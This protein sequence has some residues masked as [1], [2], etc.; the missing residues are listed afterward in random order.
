MKKQ[1]QDKTSEMIV[2]GSIFENPPIIDATEKYQFSQDDFTDRLSK[3]IFIAINNLFV[4]DVKKIEFIDI[5]KYLDTIYPVEGMQFQQVG[6]EFLKKCIR[7][8]TT[9]SSRFD[10]YYL[11]MKKMSLLRIFSLRGIDVSWIYDP[12]T[13]DEKQIDKQNK[14]LEGHTIE[15]IVNAVQARV[16]KV[17]DAFRFEGTQPAELLGTNV[18]DFITNIG[19]SPA[20]GAP[21]AGGGLMNTLTGGA[22]LG[23]FY[24]FSGSTGVGKTRTMLSHM[25][26]LATPE[27][28]DTQNKEWIK[29]EPLPAL[30]ISTELNKDELTS[31][32]L[33]FISGIDEDKILGR[34]MMN[35]EDEDIL[36]HAVEV[37][38]RTLLYYE[39]I[40]DFTVA[41]IERA[42]KINID[43]HNILYCAF[44]YISTST[45]LLSEMSKEARGVNLREDSIL[46]LLSAKLKDIANEY[47]IFMESATQL[48]RTGVNAEEPASTNMLRGASSIADKIDTGAIISRLT[49]KDIKVFNETLR[50]RVLDVTKGMSPNV[51]VNFFKNRG[52]AYNGVRLWASYDLSTCRLHPLFV[53]DNDYILRTDIVPVNLEIKKEEE[54]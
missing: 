51:T 16:D 5:Q 39:V 31:M 10:Y 38:K 23:K 27:Y 14:Y 9:E 52:L 40:T 18:D 26:Y 7:L 41:D 49:E 43:K 6:L 35:F 34:T 36:K 17:K 47:G 45:G 4:E 24:L 1:Y 20:Y 8:A 25:A 28:Y 50:T 48:N 19:N 3:Y 44:D 30:F 46:L 12:D 2:L 33:A 37:L 32:A 54:K 42:I 13:I 29:K 11:K 22:R 15:Q 21:I 53:T